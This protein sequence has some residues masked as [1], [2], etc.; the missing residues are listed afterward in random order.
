[1]AKRI[2]KPRVQC[3]G[4]RHTRDWENRSI[5]DGR[6][7]IGFCDYYPYGLLLDQKR[8]CPH[9]VPREEGRTD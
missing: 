2:E 5:D 4:C 8:P 1:M 6:L 9:F 3:R 7:L